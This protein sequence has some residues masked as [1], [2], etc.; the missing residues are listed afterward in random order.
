[1]P[2]L[3]CA[4][5]TANAG[6]CSRF[7][8]STSKYP[9]CFYNRKLGLYTR[10]RE[11]CFF[12]PRIAPELPRKRLRRPITRRVK[13]A[14]VWNYGR[15]RPRTFTLSLDTESKGRVRF[16]ILSISAFQGASI[17]A[18]A[19]AKRSVSPGSKGREPN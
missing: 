18:T 7:D 2:P 19:S 9:P 5:N 6:A 17:D 11:L 16:Y 4:L 3:L 12:T 10:K 15:K 1:M 14:C 13:A 8:L